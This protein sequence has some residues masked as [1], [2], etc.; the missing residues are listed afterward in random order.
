MKGQARTFRF[1]RANDQDHI[2]FYCSHHIYIY[3][4][5]PRH[6]PLKKQ[7]S[8]YLFFF[9]IYSINIQTLWAYEVGFHK[10]SLI[11]W[12]SER[13]YIPIADNSVSSHLN[14]F[15]WGIK[16][17]SWSSSQLHRI[18]PDKFKE[19]S[20]ALYTTGWD[21]HFSRVELLPPGVP[22]RQ[23]EGHVC[24]RLHPFSKFSHCALCNLCCISAYTVPIWQRKHSSSNL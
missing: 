2:S 16:F 7:V 24:T 10:S 22:C 6:P 15:K 9:N 3:T 14:H 5:P 12:T 17:V 13:K 20:L 19:R 23:E 11:V 8:E 21:W 1:L 4:K 18:K